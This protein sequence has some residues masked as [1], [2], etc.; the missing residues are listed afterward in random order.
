MFSISL[1]SSGMLLYTTGAAILKALAPTFVLGLCLNKVTPFPV[2][3]VFVLPRGLNTS[4]KFLR[5][6][7]QPV[8]RA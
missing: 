8:V 7:G 2:F 1:I 4:I 6:S 3:L 5:Y